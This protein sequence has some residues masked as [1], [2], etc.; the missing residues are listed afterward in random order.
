MKGVYNPDPDHAAHSMYEPKTIKT[1]KFDPKPPRPGTMP[2]KR[3]KLPPLTTCQEDIL[4]LVI[5][6]PGIRETVITN[7]LTTE[8]AYSSENVIRS[9]KL[10]K[11]AGYIDSRTLSGGGYGYFMTGSYRAKLV[12]EGA[13]VTI[14][15]AI[16]QV[17]AYDAM[18]TR[19]IATRAGISMKQASDN[20]SALKHNGELERSGDG[21]YKRPHSTGLKPEQEQKTMPEQA[22]EKTES[23]TRTK[24]DDLEN[25][26]ETL[27]EAAKRFNGAR[28]IFNAALAGLD[29][30]RK[31]G[32]IKNHAIDDLD[33]KLLT[34]NSLKMLTNAEIAATLTSI[35]EDLKAIVNT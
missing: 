23:R 7:R 31:N 34:L 26:Q 32:Q 22:P 1:A 21:Y 27:R 6:D 30:I 17:V 13:A 33:N 8:A 3:R 18:N 24:P 16:L 11:Q 15:D 12:A 19:E 35:Q 25:L 20:C 5:E 10:L 4:A 14:K 2:H 28:D 9:I 29:A